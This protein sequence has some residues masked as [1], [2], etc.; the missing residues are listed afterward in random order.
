MNLAKHLP[1]Q[2]IRFM[3]LTLKSNDDAPE[4]SVRRLY[5]SFRKLR[6]RQKMKPLIAG[7][8]AF[9]ELTYTPERR[10]FHPHLHI[11]FQGNYVPH[12][13]LRNEWLSVTGDSF[14]VDVRQVSRPD[15]A[16]G[17]VAKYASKAIGPSI[18]QDPAAFLAVIRGLE[19]VRTLF[20][21]GTWKGFKLLAAPESDTEWKTIGKLADIIK[22]ASTGDQEAQAIL[23]ALGRYIPGNEHAEETLFDGDG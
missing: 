7:G 5:A 20:T 10:Q 8:I 9:L 6:Q 14:I 18:W 19:G 13:Q 23:T 3:T 11:V 22:R 1:K 4:V 16:I 17:Y 15:H 2:R 21:F 12:A